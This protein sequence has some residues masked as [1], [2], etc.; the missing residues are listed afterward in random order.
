MENK[1]STRQQK[2]IKQLLTKYNDILLNSM[3]LSISEDFI[4]LVILNRDDTSFELAEL[5]NNKEHYYSFICKEFLKYNS[6]SVLDE[7]RTM[8][9][10]TKEIKKKIGK[11]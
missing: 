11:K 8:E 3:R 9:D 1:I 5:L 6:S 10:P 7:L 2:K 4:N